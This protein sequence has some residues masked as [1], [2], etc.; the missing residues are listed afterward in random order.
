[1]K[2]CLPPFATIIRPSPEDD[3]VIPGTEGGG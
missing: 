3:F 2:L 1:M